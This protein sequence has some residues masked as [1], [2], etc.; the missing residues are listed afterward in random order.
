M[1][2]AFVDGNHQH[3]WPLHDVL[4]LQRLMPRGW[5]LLHDI[6]LPGAGRA[7]AAESRLPPSY[8]A[9][10]VFDFWP[11]RKIAA[12]NIGAIQVTGGSAV[13]RRI[14]RQAARAAFGGQEPA[15]GSEAW[16]EID[17]LATGTASTILGLLI[18]TA[19]AVSRLR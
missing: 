9:K 15:A 19:R 8:G 2:F 5:I 10:H 17:A 13:V 1:T 12:G 6:D 16:R 3:P 11:E 14:R 7:R 4:Q 18:G